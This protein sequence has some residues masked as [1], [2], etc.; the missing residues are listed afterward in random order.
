VEARRR[1]WFDERGLVVDDRALPFYAGAM[2]YW[3]VDPARW[4][5]CLRAIRD[6]GL[7][8]VETYVPWHV[9]EPEHGERAWNDERDLAR[10]LEAARVAGLGVVL[11]PGPHPHV[12]EW[13][14][15]EPECQAR[16]AHGTPAWWPQ[17]PRA[18]PIPSYASRRFRAHVR[19]WYAHLAEVIRPYIGDP[20][21]ALGIDNEAPRSL[22]TGTYDL[23]YHSDAIAWFGEDPPRAWDPARA[24]L[25]ARW[26]EF[27]DEYIARALGDFGRML[28]EVGLGELARFHNLPPGH[29]QLYDLRRIQAQLGGPVGI[30][31][32]TPRNLFPELRWRVAALVGNARPLPLAPQ[33]G[34]GFFPWF[35]PLDWGDDPLRERDH[36]LTL[37]ASGVRGFNLCMAVERD[38]YYGA[39]I[40]GSGQ[41]E[42][43]AA[44]IRPLIAALGEI[45]WP[46]LRRPAPIALVDMRADLRAGLANTALDP[47]TPVLADVLGLGPGGAAELALDP[48]AITARRWQTAVCRALELAQVPFVIVDES[49]SAEELASYRAV[50]APTP[51]ERISPALWT[52]LCGLAEA[53]RTVVVIGPAIP[54]G[55]PRRVGKLKAGSLDD[56]A[57]LADDLAVLAGDA[58]VG[59]Q[60]AWQVEHPD[61]GRAMPFHASD[62]TVRAVFVLSDAEHGTN[63][64]L[65]TD[66]ATRSLRDPCT[67]ERIVVEGGRAVV[68]IHPRGVRLLLVA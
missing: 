39:A 60:V 9:H 48:A 34:I 6:L 2:H 65:W 56:L 32:Y 26:V 38:Q 64:T 27:K 15:A 67:Q 66:R 51:S 19:A 21:V 68:P 45:D 28:A 52:T 35:P 20:V 5:A 37:L 16:T 14:L 40:A 63:I 47:M 44:W 41:V 30:D 42:R 11:R 53:R 36:L 54:A 33:V 59:G 25:C 8:L 50:I 57:G 24:E 58:S 1:T 12:P 4:P 17:P 7:T 22:R 23:D 62:G 49:A 55:A 10:F 46:S 13:V 18:V 29:Y 43:H 61:G 3:R 31:A